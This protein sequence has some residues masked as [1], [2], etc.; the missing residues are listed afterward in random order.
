MG[1]DPTKSW[2][3][4]DFLDEQGTGLREVQ[5][6]QEELPNSNRE[7]DS[8]GRRFSLAAA[9][10]REFCLWNIL[11]VFL[12]ALFGPRDENRV[13][14]WD[15]G[16][17]WSHGGVLGTENGAGLIFRARTA[18]GKGLQ[19]CQGSFGEDFWEKF[20]TPEGAGALGK[21][22]QGMEAPRDAQGFV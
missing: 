7:S 8:L 1:F 21:A 10:P 13:Q 19:L 20:F 6:L 18:A 9:D 16:W 14:R 4:W 22:L 3:F 15:P 12:S 11:F 5:E 17:D 2:G